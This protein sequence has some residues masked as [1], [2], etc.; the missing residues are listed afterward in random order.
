MFNIPSSMFMTRC[1]CTL[2]GISSMYSIKKRHDHL[3]LNPYY[4]T[5]SSNCHII[6]WKLVYKNNYYLDFW[7][8][9]ALCL[10][11]AIFFCLISYCFR[12]GLH[13]MHHRLLRSFVA[14]SPSSQELSFFIWQRTWGILWPQSQPDWPRRNFQTTTNHTSFDY[15]VKV[16]WRWIGSIADCIFTRFLDK[17]N[18]TKMQQKASSSVN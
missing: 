13:R 2:F 3:P 11:H 9:A 17:L 8:M 1:C 5:C 4:T 12:T 16:D 10:R 18:L 7:K 6:L 14:S 15:L